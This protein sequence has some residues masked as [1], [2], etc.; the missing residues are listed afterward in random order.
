MTDIDAI[1]T[2][3]Q[4]QLPE[5]MDDLQTLVNVDCGT[6]NKAG[7]D[8]AFCPPVEKLA[9]TLTH[10][11]ETDLPKIWAAPLRI[12]TAVLERYTRF[13]EVADNLPD[14]ELWNS[15]PSPG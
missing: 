10:P 1:Q 15:Q 6:S 7:V 8:A 2:W 4:A 12:V 3:L 11:G 13:E 9:F 14:V 5:F